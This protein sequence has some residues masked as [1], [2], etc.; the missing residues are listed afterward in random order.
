MSLATHVFRIPLRVPFRGMRYREGVLVHGPEGWGECSPLP[1]VGSVDRAPWLAA[2]RE[3]ATTPW[4]DAVRTWIP[5]HSTI[6]ELSPD[7]AAG[8]ALRL[9]CSVAKIKVGDAGD[10]ARVGA[11]RRVLGPAGKIRIDAN[12]AWNVDTAVERIKRLSAFDLELVEQPCRTLE[13]MAEVRSLVEVPIAADESVRTLEDAKRLAALGAAGAVVLKVQPLGGVAAALRIA[14]AAGV[15]AI[16]SSPLETS[17]GVAAGLALAAV[18]P[19]LPFACGLATVPLLAGD[20]VVDSLV[21]VAGRITVRR[22]QIDPEAL[23]RY[24]VNAG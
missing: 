8:L 2:A 22:P 11:V 19:E 16:V 4:P 17:V 15:T 12:G 10:E 5:V 23:R 7:D 9:G 21:P 6:P 3:A 18:L 14:E 24:E 13:M 20:L 1:G